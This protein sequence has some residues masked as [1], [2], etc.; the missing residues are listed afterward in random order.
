VRRAAPA[1]LCLALLCA[2]SSPAV[3]AEPLLPDLTQETPYALGIVTD[4]THYHLGFAS[5]VYNYGDGPLRIVGSRESRDDPAMTAAQVIDLDDGTKSRVEGIGRLRYVDA[6]THRHWHYLK[7]DTY[8]LRRPDGTLA[9]PDQ[10]T[11][12]CLGDRLVAPEKGPLPAMPTF[13]EYGGNCGFDDP[14]L[15]RVDEG[16]SVGYGDDYGPQ[17]EGQFV[18]ITRLPAGRY[19]LVH[20]VNA[21]HR[22]LESSYVNNAASALL[23]LR[24]RSGIPQITILAVCPDSARCSAKH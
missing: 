24:W 20:R 9:R 14:S 5:V 8:S 12:F 18:D 2:G 7:F 3:A 17:L 1:L 4:G 10:K 23:R 16:I 22:L 6:I 11:G 19:V 15:M 13:G 21:D